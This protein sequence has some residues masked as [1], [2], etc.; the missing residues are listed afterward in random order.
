MRVKICFFLQ[1]MQKTL[2]YEYE[3][4]NLLYFLQHIQKNSI[5]GEYEGKNA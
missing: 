2:Y 1:P 5:L 4:K 3:G